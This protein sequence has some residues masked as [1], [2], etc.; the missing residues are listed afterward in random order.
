MNL[1]KVEVGF[2][3]KSGGSVK[4]QRLIME[5]DFSTL[6]LAQ[7]SSSKEKLNDWAKSFFPAAEWAKV[8]YMK[9]IRK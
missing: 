1:V 4:E 5:V 7:G 9:E 3:V 6:K 2:S 8:I